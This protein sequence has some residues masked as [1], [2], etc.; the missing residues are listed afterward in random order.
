[1]ASVPMIVSSQLKSHRP[2]SHQRISWT[3]VACHQRRVLS[4]AAKWGLKSLV[5]LVTTALVCSGSATAMRGDPIESFEIPDGWKEDAS[6]RDV[7]FL[8]DRL[9][10]GGSRDDSADV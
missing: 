3:R 10:R 4:G 9:G 5:M 1:M 8:D 7:F 2:K 6:I